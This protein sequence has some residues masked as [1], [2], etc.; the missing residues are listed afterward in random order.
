MESSQCCVSKLKLGSLAFKACTDPT[1]NSYK[2]V[3]KEPC[4]QDRGN[5]ESE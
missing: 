5:C 1:N 3:S 4:E 2:R